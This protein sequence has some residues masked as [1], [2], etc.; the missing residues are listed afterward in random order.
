MATDMSGLMRSGGR[1]MRTGMMDG[2]GAMPK[3]EQRGFTVQAPGSESPPEQF[4]Y[5]PLEGTPGAWAVYPPGIPCDT[6]TYRISRAD[7][8]PAADFDKMQ[9]ALD[10]AGAE[11]E[12]PAEDMSA[13]EEQPEEMMA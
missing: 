4:I 12:S 5:E 8:A 3:G 9:A 2:M 7:P 13:G 1:G 6:S 11:T 10:D